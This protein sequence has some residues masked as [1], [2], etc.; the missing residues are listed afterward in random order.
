MMLMGPGPRFPRWSREL[1]LLPRGFPVAICGG[2]VGER[3]GVSPSL[4][5]AYRIFSLDHN[6]GKFSLCI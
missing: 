5:G 4:G 2:F 1:G 3:A 6:Q